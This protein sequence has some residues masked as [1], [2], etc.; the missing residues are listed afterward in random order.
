MNQ[1]LSIEPLKIEACFCA[2]FC[3]FLIGF[4]RQWWG[5]PAGIRTSILVCL[6]A[7]TYIALANFY[8][9]EIG[10]V[11]VLGSV[12]TGV[13]FLGAGMMLSKEASNNIISRLFKV[14]YPPSTRL[15]FWY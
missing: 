10:G 5:K 1:I 6:G 11:R 13:G 8:Q 2:I 9:E 7:Y 3:G 14:E 4:E 15:A 12:V